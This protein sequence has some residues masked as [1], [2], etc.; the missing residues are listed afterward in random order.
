MSQPA[1]TIATRAVR[2]AA[3]E[4]LKQ[5]N[6][7]DG[8]SVAKKLDRYVSDT[9]ALSAQAIVQVIQKSFPRDEILLQETGG[10]PDPDKNHWII[11]PLD[12]KTNF[13]HGIPHFAISICMIKQNKI[14]AAVV[15]D[16]VKDELFTAYRG[17][18]SILNGHTIR[19][20]EETDAEDKVLA[21]TTPSQQHSGS[22]K[23]MHTLRAFHRSAASIRCT[24]VA[25]LDLA[26]VAA[27]RLDGFWAFRQNIWDS[28]AGLLLATEAGGIAN[29]CNLFGKSKSSDFNDILAANTKKHEIFM[30]KVIQDSK[31]II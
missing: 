9:Y 28:S 25:N 16:P 29:Q 30:E 7:R 20:N 15:Y 6:R 31:K 1:V 11:N 22:S 21:T 10:K 5:I 17:G 3:R 4:I 24:G 19:V 14:E 26:Y 27:G 23:Y 13:L 8:I 18:K 2:E 12:G